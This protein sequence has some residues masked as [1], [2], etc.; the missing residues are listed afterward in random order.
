MSTLFPNPVEPYVQHELEAVAALGVPIKAVLSMRSPARARAGRV[1]VLE[2]A[3][4]GIVRGCLHAVRHPRRLASVVALLVRSHRQDLSSLAP[5]R[6]SL[7][8]SLLLLPSLLDLE[9]RLEPSVKHFHAHFA[10]VPTTLAMALARWRRGSYSFTAHGGDLLQYPPQ[11][12]AARVNGA[13][14]CATVSEFN[15]EHIGTHYPEADADKVV[16]VRCGVDVRRFARPR[17]ELPAGAVRLLTVARLHPVKGIDTFLQALG[18]FAR[19]RPEVSFSYTIVGDGPARAAL[20]ALNRSE[21]LGARVRFTGQLSSDEVAEALAAADVFVLPSHSEG[22]PVALIEAVAAG[23]PLL[24][25]R[26]TGI[27]E[28]LAEDQNGLFLRPGDARQQRSVLELLA[29]HGWA[30]LRAL[31]RGAAERDLKDFELANTAARM[32]EL[33]E[34]AGTRG[35]QERPARARGT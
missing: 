1:P 32:A 9:R 4:L 21:E 20:E 5:G 28:L 12:L 2:P 14:F 35:A 34:R 3:R 23:L 27:P 11:D 33:L 15:R 6:T 10:S 22:L 13:T 26:I 18:A 8:K 17:R 25:S 16:V 19:D 7:L 29:S 31:Q 24:A 30:K